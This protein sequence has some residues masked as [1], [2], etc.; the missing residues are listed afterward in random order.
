MS[1]V[2]TITKFNKYYQQIH[3]TGITCI[4]SKEITTV[5]AVST[6]RQLVATPFIPSPSQHP[7]SPPRK[8][9][10]ISTDLFLLAVLD[11]LCADLDVGTIASSRQDLGAQFELEALLGKATLE[12]FGNLHVDAQAAHMSQELH[13]RH[14]RS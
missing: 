11:A 2:T 7:Q 14:L 4:A 6:P 3:K 8:S 9:E 12:S 13:T 1:N 5:M 10:T